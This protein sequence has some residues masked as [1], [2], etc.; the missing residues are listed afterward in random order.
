MVM[1]H[2]VH[3][4]KSEEQSLHPCQIKRLSTKQ[5]NVHSLKAIKNHRCVWSADP[6]LLTAPNA[7]II[8]C[9]K[10]AEEINN[11][12]TLV[13]H[14]LVRELATGLILPCSQG[15]SHSYLYAALLSWLTGSIQQNWC[16]RLLSKMFHSSPNGYTGVPIKHALFVPPPV[17]ADHLIWGLRSDLTQ[18]HMMHL[19]REVF[20]CTRNKHLH[21][22]TSILPLYVS[23][24]T[25]EGLVLYLYLRCHQAPSQFPP[26]KLPLLAPNNPLLNNPKLSSF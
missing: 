19:T 6:D 1:S 7:I 2:L 8:I 26:F 24:L 25:G 4:M 17:G 3:N 11:C 13:P 21:R 18:D 10:A 9:D 22:N 12:P 20:R 23:L 5:G 15:C 14:W 16:C